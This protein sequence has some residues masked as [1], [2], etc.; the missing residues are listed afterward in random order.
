MCVIHVLGILRREFL[1]NGSMESEVWWEVLGLYK[2]GSSFPF[3][4]LK[5]ERNMP[6]TKGYFSE[7]VN[8][9][10]VGAKNDKWVGD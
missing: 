9:A 8:D 4:L 1:L 5:G 3:F 10:G 2:Y 6:I 7:G